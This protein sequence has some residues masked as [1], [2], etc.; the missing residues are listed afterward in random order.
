IP[1]SGISRYRTRSSGL[2][3]HERSSTIYQKPSLQA[4]VHYLAAFVLLNTLF[5]KQD[6]IVIQ[7][8]TSL[9][10]SAISEYPGAKSIV[11]IWDKHPTLNSPWPFF[12]LPA[13]PSGR[14]LSSMKLIYS[15]WH[16][17][18]VFAAIY[19]RRRRSSGTGLI[20]ILLS[21]MD[22]PVIRLQALKLGHYILRS[23]LTSCPRRVFSH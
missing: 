9:S 7:K 16:S 3:S 21:V 8:W 6:A 5:C 13:L 15:L 17:S 22:V 19:L 1:S 20:L 12:D 4:V 18:R 11:L 2:I 14:V 23:G 10:Y